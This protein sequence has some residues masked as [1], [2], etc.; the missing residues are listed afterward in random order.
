MKCWPQ[1]LTR[2]S[3]WG[4]ALH[5][6]HRHTRLVGDLR[7]RRRLDALAG[8]Q[9]ERAL[10]DPLAGGSTSRGSP[11]SSPYAASKP[12]RRASCQN[13][14]WGDRFGAGAS[15]SARCPRGVSCQNT[16]RPTLRR[17]TR[18]LSS[19]RRP[20]RLTWVSSVSSRRRSSALPSCGEPSST[21]RKSWACVPW[22]PRPARARARAP[23]A[24][25][26]WPRPATRPALDRRGPRAAVA[27]GVEGGR[28]GLVV[29]FEQRVDQAERH[30]L[31]TGRLRVEP[32]SA[33]LQRDPRVVYG[34][35]GHARIVANHVN[36]LSSVSETTPIS[37]ASCSIGS[38]RRVP[39]RGRGLDGGCEG[40]GHR[41]RV[42]Q[43]ALDGEPVAAPDGGRETS[44]SCSASTPPSPTPTR[45]SARPPRPPSPSTR[46]AT[47]SQ[48]ASTP[49]PFPAP[50]SP[51]SPARA[52]AANCP[53]TWPTPSARC[54][55]QLGRLGRLRSRRPA[56]ALP[57]DPAGARGRPPRS[58]RPMIREPDE[59]E[60][61]WRSAPGCASIGSI[62]PIA[63]PRGRG[64]RR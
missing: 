26:R 13:S 56:G 35:R 55:R 27:E 4:T 37:S 63:S 29:A 12:R 61:R 2:S 53:T 38:T 33:A 54:A 51:A 16:W 1:L 52:A 32:R 64:W 31:Q 7:P 14:E 57:P 43:A 58:H 8:V 17:V 22:P 39:R 30:G 21:R 6:L 47:R 9:L 28:K 18:P 44:P 45:C 49:V 62:L 5:G 36:Y 24:R 20:V 50:S 11:G 34:G 59:L 25:R 19:R 48:A 3:W 42:E 15:S 60:W 46:S 10:D 41:R 23:S 40:R